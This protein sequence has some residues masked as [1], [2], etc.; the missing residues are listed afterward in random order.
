[1]KGYM[2]FS[3]QDSVHSDGSVSSRVC[4]FQSD[5]PGV[6]N[7]MPH[8]LTALHAVSKTNRLRYDRDNWDDQ[9]VWS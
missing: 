5:I 4:N 8:I 7:D 1:M 9:R 2:R 3:V 6:L